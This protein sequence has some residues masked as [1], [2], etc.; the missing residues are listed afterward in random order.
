LWNFTFGLRALVK[1]SPQKWVPAVFH[2][3][4]KSDPGMQ[5]PFLTIQ[6]IPFG[7]NKVLDFFSHCIF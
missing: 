7:Q 4:L 3:G 5:C 2:S 6:S 1:K